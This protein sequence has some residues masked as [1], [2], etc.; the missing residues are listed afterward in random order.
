MN[1]PRTAA[2]LSDAITALE[3][4]VE[5][6]TGPVRELTGQCAQA[7][8]QT[9]ALTRRADNITVSLARLSEQTVRMSAQ[10]GQD[11]GPGREKEDTP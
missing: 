2:A 10:L 5:S 6:A 7:R 3:Q 11:T 1:D 9:R 8:E 4:A